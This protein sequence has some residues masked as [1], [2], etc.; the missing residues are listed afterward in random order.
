MDGISQQDYPSDRKRSR[1]TM[2]HVWPEI[3]FVI[4]DFI[5]YFGYGV[6]P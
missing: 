4:G 2:A 6:H 3:D 1:D 5:E